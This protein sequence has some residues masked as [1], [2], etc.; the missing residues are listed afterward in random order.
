[1]PFIDRCAPYGQWACL[2]IIALIMI[3][4]F[5]LAVW[6]FDAKPS[7]SN[8]FSTYI[9]APLYIADYFIYKV[10]FVLFSLLSAMTNS[11]LLQWWYKTSIVAP[12]D[13]DFSEAAWFNED[14]RR[15]EEEEAANPPEKMSLRKRLVAGIVG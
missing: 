3:A 4:E 1:M 9:S 12:K 6:P 2:V 8:F 13:M 7:A 14:D 10:S 5:Y 15:M 11:Y